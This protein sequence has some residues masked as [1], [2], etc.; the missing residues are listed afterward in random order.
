M[1]VAFA[2]DAAI[3]HDDRADRRIRRGVTDSARSELVG[4]L[5][6]ERVERR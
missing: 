6:V 3:A 5:Q 2:D 4:A 1:M